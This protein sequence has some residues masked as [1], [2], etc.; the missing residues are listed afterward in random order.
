MIRGRKTEKRNEI[1]YGESLSGDAM[2]NYAAERLKQYLIWRGFNDRPVAGSR[3]CK[4]CA[5][6][7]RFETGDTLTLVY[8]TW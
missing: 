7:R 8:Q 2:V 6:N 5:N 1:P 3:T 4:R